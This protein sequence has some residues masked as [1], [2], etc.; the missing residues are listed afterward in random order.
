MAT[1]A[2]PISI[3]MV[4]RHGTKGQTLD[5]D[6]GIDLTTTTSRELIAINIDD[7]QVQANEIIV[8]CDISQD[9]TTH[10]IYV[11][12]GNEFEA[13]YYYVISRAT[14]DVDTVPYSKNRRILHVKGKLEE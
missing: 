5:I 1:T 9:D 4:I 7:D 2:K 13:G 11:T 14:F 10:M 3:D 12:S 6:M 8:Q